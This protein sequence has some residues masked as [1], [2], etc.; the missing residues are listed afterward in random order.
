MC[1][2]VSKCACVRAGV[3]P[4]MFPRS[5]E[6]PFA[7][8]PWHA[9]CPQPLLP[10]RAVSELA[11]ASALRWREVFSLIYM[12]GTRKPRALSPRHNRSCLLL[13][14]DYDQTGL[15]QLQHFPLAAVAG[16]QAELEE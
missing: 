12:R 7:S 8:V 6:Q 9:A 10:F 5:V 14:S 1:A 2:C 3:Q 16:K 11:P 4:A 13:I 15:Q